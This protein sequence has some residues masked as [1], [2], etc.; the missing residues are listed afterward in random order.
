MTNNNNDNATDETMMNN[1]NYSSSLMKSKQM[2]EIMI[3][4][5]IVGIQWATVVLLQQCN[6]KLNMHFKFEKSLGGPALKMSFISEAETNFEIP[7]PERL[8]PGANIFSTS[9]SGVSYNDVKRM[10]FNWILY[11]HTSICSYCMHMTLHRFISKIIRIKR[12]PF[13]YCMTMHR[14]LS[15]I[16]KWSKENLFATVWLYIALYS[17]K[18]RKDQKKTFIYLSS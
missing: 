6:T 14:F 4:Y 1:N 15:K 17:I 5:S 11:V 18:N 13:C 2:N 9:L 12:K 7:L 8:P 3:M 16:W 10:P